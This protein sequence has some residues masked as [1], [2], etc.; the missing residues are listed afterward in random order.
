[1]TRP[2]A[3]EWEAVCQDEMRAF[4]YLGGESRPTVA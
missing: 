1:M 2:E 4:E 3:A